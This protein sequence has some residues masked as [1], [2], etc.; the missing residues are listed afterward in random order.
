[1]IV[2]TEFDAWARLCPI[3]IVAFLFVTLSHD[4]D[5]YKRFGGTSCFH[6]QDRSELSEDTIRLY[7]QVSM[8]VI[9]LE[10]KRSC[11]TVRLNWNGEQEI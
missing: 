6:H 10:G 9:T 11:S 3:P 2:S 8:N 4:E 7:M 5:G 1:M